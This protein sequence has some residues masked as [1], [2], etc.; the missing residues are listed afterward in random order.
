MAPPAG[1]PSLG[2]KVQRGQVLAYVE[3]VAGALER[4][5]QAAQIAELR[6]GLGLAEKRLARLQELSDTVPRREIETAK[7]Q[8]L[9]ELWG[10]SAELATIISAKAIRR[11]LSE[12]DHRRL[13]D[14]ALTELKQRERR[15]A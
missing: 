12:E 13:L 9:S 15:S 14:E 7:D 2:Q 5:G 1:L 8:A 4:S 11:S 3:P 10:K 6:A